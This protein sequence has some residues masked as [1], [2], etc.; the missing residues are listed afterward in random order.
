MQLD[1]MIKMILQNY[2]TFVQSKIYMIDIV[3]YILRT[4]IYYQKARIKREI[5]LALYAIYTWG[6]KYVLVM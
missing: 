4:P 5:I 6:S 2:D 3:R 1:I